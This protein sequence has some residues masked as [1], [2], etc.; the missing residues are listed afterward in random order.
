MVF[1]SRWR[2]HRSSVDSKIRDIATISGADWRRRIAMAMPRFRF[3]VSTVAIVLGLGGCAFL[4]GLFSGSPTTG[5][6][7][8][9][10]LVAEG[11]TSP[12]KLAAASDGS[13]RLFVADQIGVIRI[14]DGAGQLLPTPFLDIRDRTI[15][16]NVF[17]DERGLL[18][19]ALHPD[20]GANGRFFVYYSAPKGAGIPAEFD[21]E[22]RVS[23][24]QASAGDPNLADVTTE[25]VVMRIGQPQANHNGGDLVFD[26]G[27]L[28]HVA[29]GDGGAAGD[30]GT[31]HTPG[32]GNA[33]DLSGLLGKVLRIDVDGAQPYAIP[34]DNP[35]VG[36]AGAREEIF[37]Y[38]LRNPYRMSFDSGGEHRLFVGDVGQGLIEEVDI[39]VAGGN[40]GWRIREGTTCFDPQNANVPLA[41][42]PNSS[43]DGTTLIP[44]IVEYGHSN[45]GGPQGLS[46]I[47]GHVYRG[48]A[49]GE[50]AGRY[51]FG[52]WTRGFLGG[53]DGSL[54]V[55]TQNA[56]GS[57]SLDE[58]SIAGS[59][60]GRLG[61]Y[62]LGF[63]E[64]TDGEIYV[65]TSNSSS[66]TGTQG[67]VFKVISAN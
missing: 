37:A 43:A 9:L 40:Y 23:E 48:G 57:W 49:I 39:V 52:D 38:G 17:G 2:F 61:R 50:L 41:N 13:S 62:V 33:Q 1:M 15:A 47:G 60:N 35:F 26:P 10:Q 25:R 3:V 22:S 21:H 24:F 20:F 32:L 45:P 12:V 31:G 59:A 53:P 18:G 30:M 64:D 5:S 36:V 42:C 46:V 63:G 27:G 54:F 8:G 65:V 44:P 6:T 28:L 58:L 67:R 7:V 51:I 4:Q 66:P 19:L 34:P 56:D 16:L 14:I 55:A 29:T 11:L